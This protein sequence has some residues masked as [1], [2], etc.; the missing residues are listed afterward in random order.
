MVLIVV[1]PPQVGG[2]RVE[3]KTGKTNPLTIG[4]VAGKATK[5][6]SV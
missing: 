3:P 5:K 2:V 4:I 6:V 1:D